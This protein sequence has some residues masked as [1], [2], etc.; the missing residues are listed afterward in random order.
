MKPRVFVSSTYYDLK[1]IRNSIERFI[2]QYGFEPV[3]FESGN[4]F[5]EHDKELDISC[6]NEVKLC[7]IMILIIG[8]RYGAPSSEEKHKEFISKYEKNYISITRKEF[9]E[10]F[11]NN[12]PVFIFVDKNVYGEYH[13]FKKNQ[14]FFNDILEKENSEFKFAHVDNVNIF[15][16]IDEVKSKPL[17]TFEKFD[18]IEKYIR[19]QWAGMFFNYINELKKNKD[20]NEILSS[21]TDLKN[22]TDRMNEMV[23]EI[24]K[25][26][27]TESDNYISTVKKQNEKTINLYSQKIVDLI[28][29][30]GT[31][32]TDKHKNGKSFEVT[33]LIY[34]QIIINPLLYKDN[35]I[36]ESELIVEDLAIN[37]A[38]ELNEK[39]YKIDKRIYLESIDIISILKIYKGK[40]EPII[41][42]NS[43]K[44]LF[45]S[46]LEE[47]IDYELY[48]PF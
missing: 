12:I 10:A 4:V 26:I 40:I 44:A 13:T 38:E 48:G 6:Y 41:N 37:V 11:D 42:D 1:H 28:K 39:L 21:V 45:K 18:D 20:K 47:A 2:I 29:L 43:N 30:G 25:Q 9:R 33:E 32:I 14:Q 8:G 15:N 17:I 36:R 31:W 16:F 5:F 24:G 35:S 19:E 3:L 23:D 34:D 7:H 46:K 27:L 22:I